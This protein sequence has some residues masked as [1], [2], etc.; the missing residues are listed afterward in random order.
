MYLFSR[1]RVRQTDR[2]RERDPPKHCSVLAYGG[3]GS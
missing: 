1:K 2:Q 3:A